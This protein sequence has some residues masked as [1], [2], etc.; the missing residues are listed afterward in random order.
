MSVSG[1][2]KTSLCEVEATPA[3][4]AVQDEYVRLAEKLWIG[5]APLPAVAMKD[6]DIFDLL[7]FD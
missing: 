4:K 3:I 5:G 1:L 6:R 2:P 7:G